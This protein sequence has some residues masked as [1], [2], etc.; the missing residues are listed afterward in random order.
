VQLAQL[1]GNYIIES[2]LVSCFQKGKAL[3]CG[4]NGSRD[5][6]FLPSLPLYAR[7]PIRS[8]QPQPINKAGVEDC[9]SGIYFKGPHPAF[10][11]YILIKIGGW[12]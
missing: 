6:E 8:P 2:S 10:F 4:L 5:I 7:Y 3:I 12:V 1:V 11:I 9:E